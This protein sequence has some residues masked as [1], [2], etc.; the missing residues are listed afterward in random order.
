MTLIETLQAALE[1][2]CS[3]PNPPEYVLNNL[4]REIQTLQGDA[5]INKLKGE[6]C[7]FVGNNGDQP[8]QVYFDLKSAQNDE[9]EFID[10]FD[11]K[12]IKVQVYTLEVDN[13]YHIQRR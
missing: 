12:G 9:H 5:V 2:V 6:G 13:Q 11:E 4:R 7:Y 1:C 8:D 10:V 3:L